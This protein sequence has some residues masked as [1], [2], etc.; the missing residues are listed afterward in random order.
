MCLQ[1]EFVTAI[2]QMQDKEKISQTLT[3]P[4]GKK[5]KMH[6]AERVP[7]TLECTQQT[8]PSCRSLCDMWADDCTF[9]EWFCWTSVYNIHLYIMLGEIGL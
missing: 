2:D 4:H 7:Y 9:N 5:E 1:T 8:A 3:K 6:Q